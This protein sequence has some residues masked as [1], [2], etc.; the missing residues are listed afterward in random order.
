MDIFC[1]IHNLTST[2]HMNSTDIWTFV[3]AYVARITHWGRVTHICVGKLIII[4]SDNGL[5]PGRRQAITWTNAG[6][7]FIR[8]LGTN[9]SGI[10][11][12]I[13]TFS[14]KKMHLKISS[15]RCRPFCLGLNVIIP[16][17]HRD[18]NYRT[19]D[20][21]ILVIWF[22]CHEYFTSFFALVKCTNIIKLRTWVPF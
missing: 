19:M 22:E 3:N 21:I 17:L 15:A 7:L 16:V 13:E 5:S 9:F 6:I 10:S 18:H 20:K 14:F 2:G 8:P 12:S 1:D 11:I 4:G